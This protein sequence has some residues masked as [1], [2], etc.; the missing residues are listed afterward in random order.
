VPKAASGLTPMMHQ[1][2]RIKETV[3]Q[4]ILMFRIGDFYEMLEDDAVLAARVLDI[5]LTKKHIGQGKTVPLAGVPYHSVQPYI[6]KLTRQGYRVA[7]CEQTTEPEK[8]K[9]I[10]EREVVRTI[11]PGTLMDEGALGETAN[12]YLAA[13]FDGNFRGFGLAFTDISTGEFLVTTLEGESALEDLR[14]ELLKVGPSEC[15]LPAGLPEDSGLRRVVETEMGI[16]GT[17]RPF[18][19]FTPEPVLSRNMQIVRRQENGRYAR[20][21]VDEREV[22]QPEGQLTLAL[23]S[24]GAVL[25]FLAETQKRELAHIEQV[26]VYT[27]SSYMLIDSATARNLELL[28]SLRDT[29]KTGTLLGVLDRTLTPMGGRLLKNWIARPLTRRSEIERRH[30]AVGAL[31]QDSIL[32]EE[33]RRFLEEIGDLER[34]VGRA[35]FGNANGRDLVG[36]GHSLRK[37]PE[38]RQKIECA[39]QAGLNEYFS[40]KS[41]DDIPELTDELLRAFVDEPP[42][43]VR[44]GG[45]IRKGYRAELD[46]LHAI[47]KD[48]KGWMARFQTEERQKTEIPSLKV[49]YNKVFGYY[50]EVTKAHQDKIPPEYIRKQTLVNA[51]RFITEELKNYESRVL[52]AQER[53][54][55][56][57][58]ELFQQLRQKAAGQ[59]GRIRTTAAEVA[60][61]DVLCALAEAAARRDYTRP[62]MLNKPALEIKG[63][64]HPVLEQ[65]GW[66]DQFVPNDLVMNGRDEQLYV[67]TGPNMAGKSTF[68]RQAA[69]IVLMA[70]MGSFVPAASARIG[71]VD[72]IFT[73]VGA[74]DNL[75]AGQ[76]TFMVE[77]SEAANILRYATPRSLII[78]DEIGRGTSTFDGVS[79]AWAIAEYLHGLQG[80]GVKTLFATHYHEL[81]ELGEQ[82]PRARNFRVLVSEKS[83]RVTF[84]YKVAPG[85]TDH[86]YGIH[87]AELAGLPK[88]VLDRARKILGRLEQENLTGLAGQSAP[89]Q[90]EADGMQLSLFSMVEEP[91]AGRLRQL[92]VNTMSPVEALQTLSELIEEVK[93]K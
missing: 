9:K 60:E 72:R 87:V 39:D 32:R 24:A 90:S 74:S 59:A 73:R 91:I 17:P 48:G 82:L 8:G 38:I 5:T 51:E 81:A 55:H 49:G 62:K 26:E 71:M 3:G 34:L 79:L 37:A 10:V 14:A 35:C 12:N 29:G 7:I 61:L 30:A 41:F 69:L 16:I 57:E 66:V 21:S 47:Q 92:D 31:V 22:Q 68:I 46:E 44:E 88:K 36:L 84:L 93:R 2:Q 65:T 50:I 64:R 52:S 23:R 77:M 53:I 25:N 13:V 43:T 1:Y 85:S 18:E 86:S 70:Q 63:G 33:L 20:E 15:L 76:S 75:V 28:K 45:M 67:I 40:E 56:L 4:A 78:L 6:R 19:S 80:K 42:L 58:Y 27:A 11:T 89:A 54:A 83:G